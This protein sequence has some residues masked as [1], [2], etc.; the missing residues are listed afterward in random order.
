MTGFGLAALVALSMTPAGASA[1]NGFPAAKA[2]VDEYDPPPPQNPP[3]QGQPPQNPG[4]GNG[5]GNGNGPKPPKKGG[6]ASKNTPKKK[7]TTKKGCNR[8]GSKARAAQAG[9]PA[10][11]AGPDSAA[12]G[13]GSA[14]NGINNESGSPLPFNASQGGKLPF[15]GLDLLMV[16]SLGALLL[17]MGFG[18]RVA[19]RTRRRPTA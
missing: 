9:C 13:P 18:F 15:T 1:Q 2:A 10:G 17:A 6:E 4:N 7:S 11:G 14:V 5:N 3:G 16:S 19:T 12:G 8:T